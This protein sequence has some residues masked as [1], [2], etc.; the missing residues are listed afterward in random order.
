MTNT[1]STIYTTGLEP[2]E[3]PSEQHIVARKLDFL[4]D[5]GN[6]LYHPSPRALRAGHSTHYLTPD[7]IAQ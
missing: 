1:E 3:D 5:G 2:F 6:F 4:S 7:L